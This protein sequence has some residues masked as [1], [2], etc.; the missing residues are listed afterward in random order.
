MY[1]ST[2]NSD[3]FLERKKIMSFVTVLG[4]RGLPSQALTKRVTSTALFFFSFV[5]LFF[6]RSVFFSFLDNF[7]LYLT[8]VLLMLTILRPDAVINRH[9][10]H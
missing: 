2:Y 8:N 10:C 1:N 9:K 4:K 5:S 3:L 7:P 6:F